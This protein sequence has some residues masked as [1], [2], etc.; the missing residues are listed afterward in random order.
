MPRSAFRYAYEVHGVFFL[1]LH[2]KTTFCCHTSPAEDAGP[3][4]R[5]PF[6][7]S[8]TL[9]E[10]VL[11]TRPVILLISGTRNRLSVIVEY[12]NPWTTSNW[13]FSI[14]ISYATVFWLKLCL[15]VNFQSEDL[16]GL[17]GKS[18]NIS[19][20]SNN[21]CKEDVPCE[22]GAD[23]GLS[24]WSNCKISAKERGGKHTR[25][26]DSTFYIGRSWG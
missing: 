2:T 26:L 13:W 22:D 11:A 7:L 10:S 5:V 8:P 23:S 24:F 6:L 12:V 25:L 19:R 17:F 20:Q 4:L 1:G 18:K 14:V 9:L 15:R 16:T 3:A 21:I